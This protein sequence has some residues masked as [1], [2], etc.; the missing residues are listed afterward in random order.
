V[1]WVLDG[2][3]SCA[4]VREHVRVRAIS[5]SVC[6]CAHLCVCVHS[7]ARTLRACARVRAYVR[8]RES[9]CAL[10]RAFPSDCIF[11]LLCV[12]SMCACASRLHAPSHRTAPTCGINGSARAAAVVAARAWLRLGA[13]GRARARR[14]QVSP[15]RTARPRRNGLAD[16]GTRP[17]STPPAPSTSSAETTAT[18]TSRTCGRAPTEVRCPTRSSVWWGVL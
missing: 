9:A 3:L 8:A 2:V 10:G 17:S 14:P 13:T 15:G 6:T 5:V 4:C 7:C 16:L 11:A 12:A 18:A 1:C